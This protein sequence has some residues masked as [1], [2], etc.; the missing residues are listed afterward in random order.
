MAAQDHHVVDFQKGL[1]V[2]ETSGGAF[3]GLSS[4]N[5][6]PGQTE[7]DRKVPQGFN[8]Q[9]I[10]LEQPQQ[11][12]NELNGHR[13]GPRGVKRSLVDAHFKANKDFQMDMVVK[14]MQELDPNKVKK[15]RV[16]FDL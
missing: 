5:L 2:K 10:D 12:Q 7:S 8:G 1:R 15:K 9:K 11:A 16:R 14:M 6:F 13:F 4:T 3:E